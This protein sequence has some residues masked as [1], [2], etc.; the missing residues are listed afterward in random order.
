MARGLADD[1]RVRRAA[2]GTTVTLRHRVSRPVHLFQGHV[3]AAEPAVPMRA[4]GRSGGELLVVGDVDQ[5]SAERLRENLLRLTDGGTTAVTVDLSSVSVLG[6]AGVQVLAEVLAWPVTCLELVASP[7]TA[8]Q[9]VLET[10]GLPYRA[11]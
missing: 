6:S 4:E 1:V 8:A 9:H 11:G 2:D 7:G 3:A 5:D 10:V